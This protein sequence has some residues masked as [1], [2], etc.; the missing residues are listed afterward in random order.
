MKFN[1]NIKEF[2]ISTLISTGLI[3]GGFA[4]GYYAHA[5]THPPELEL[6]LLSQA[7]V[8]LENHALYDLPD[9][10]ALEYG[11]IR[12]MLDAYGDPHTY[13]VEPVEHELQ[14]D[15]LE[16]SYGGIGSSIQRDGDNFFVL[17]PF[18][19]SPAQQAGIMDGD[20]LVKVDDLIITADMDVHAIASAIRGPE[21]EKVAVTVARAPDFEE[22]EFNIKRQSFNLPSVT[23]HA[24]AENSRLGVIEVNLIGANT[25]AEIENAFSDLSAKGADHLVLDLRGNGGGY[26]DSGIEIARLFLKKGVVIHRQYKGKAVEVIEAQKDGPLSN[27]PLVILIDQG[28]ASASEIIAGSLQSQGRALL[29]GSDSYGKNSIQLVFDLDDGSSIRVT[30]AEWWI[31]GWDFPK[32][33]QGLYPDFPVDPNDERPNPLI[34]TALIIFF[35]AE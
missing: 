9:E 5:N 7:K 25:P 13:F 22:F 30:N 20:R 17:Y 23:W 33:G 3:A 31:P 15:S 16:G 12:G 32:P 1:F 11:M 29:I 14:Y 24:A 35:E 19:D 6:P 21:G 4:L 34:A 28:T 10:R 26:L 8:I 2:L 18:Q 27:I